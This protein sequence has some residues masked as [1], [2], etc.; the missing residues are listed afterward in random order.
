M[1]TIR[2]SCAIVCQKNWHKF[3]PFYSKKRIDIVTYFNCQNVSLKVPTSD[4]LTDRKKL[5]TIDMIVCIAKN[6]SFSFYTVFWLILFLPLL[7]VR[8]ETFFC[9]M[10]L[11]KRKSNLSFIVDTKKKNQCCITKVKRESKSYPCISEIS[12]KNFHE[13]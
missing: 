3:K 7:N 13:K 11:P 2:C 8:I 1:I 9:T 4:S 5:L 6:R 10:E 12:E